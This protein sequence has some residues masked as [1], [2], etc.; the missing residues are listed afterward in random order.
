M[1]SDNNNLN[2][3]LDEEFLRKLEKLKLLIQKGLKGPFKGEH[4]SWRSGASLEFLDYRKYQAGDDFRYVDWNVFGRLD[5]LFIKLFRS[6]E[7]LTIHILI[8]MSRSMEVGDPSKVL[9]AKKIT[10]ALSYIGLANL[11]KVGVTSF[12]DSLDKP[13]SPER[14]K[15]VYLSIL[16]Y[17]NSVK[18]DGI[19]KLNECLSEYASTCK[20]PGV[21]IVISDFLYPYGFKNGLE[22]LHHAGFNVTLIQIL[23]HE[24]LFP[25]LDGYI[26][27][28]EIETDEMRKATVDSALLEAYKESIALFLNDTQ[29]LC[30]KNR[31]DYYLTDTGIP[32]EEFLLDYLTKS[33]LFHL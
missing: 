15:Q 19:T 10:A 29:E 2:E 8:D 21:A 32:F 24:E 4:I 31:V 3:L 26:Q 9:Y 16:K 28:R 7:D 11:D 14:G 12:T 27:L 25:T 17:L 1:I 33:V 23:D 13:C 5:K 18:P 20:R 30:R 6:E 22:S